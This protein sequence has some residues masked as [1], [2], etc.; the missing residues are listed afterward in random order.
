[1]RIEQ[2]AVAL[3]RA[4]DEALAW[5]ISAI[6]KSTWYGQRERLRFN[7]SIRLKRWLLLAEKIMPGVHRPCLSCVPMLT[8]DCQNDWPGV[9]QVRCK[10]RAGR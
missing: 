2:F 1:V 8:R 10:A 9:R 4:V 3:H 6:A 7:G 5:R